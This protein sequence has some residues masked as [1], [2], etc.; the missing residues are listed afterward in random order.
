M[1]GSLSQKRLFNMNLVRELNIIRKE[2]TTSNLLLI[3]KES[4]GL[5]YSFLNEDAKR[6]VV[7][8]KD[9]VLIT[10]L[11]LRSTNGILQGEDFQLFKNT[12]ENFELRVKSK[13][14][15]Q[16]LSAAPPVTGTGRNSESKVAA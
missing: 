6:K 8:L 4:N 5:E 12:F 14:L 3:K 15:Y 2:I 7:L 11:S 1:S 9:P 16:K 10:S 13:K